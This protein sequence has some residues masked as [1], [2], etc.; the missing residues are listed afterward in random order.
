MN[1]GGLK[2]LLYML[3]CREM[4]TEPGSQI[5]PNQP[6]SMEQ[7]VDANCRRGAGRVCGWLL[8]LRG[9][10]YAGLFKIVV[11]LHKP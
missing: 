6:R 10:I 3:F 8:L 4:Y 7:V 11:R 1:D 9:Q 2:A 5:H